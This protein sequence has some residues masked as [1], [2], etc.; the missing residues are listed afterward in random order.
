MPP[1]RLISI[2]VPVL[3]E[4]Q[5]V[6]P[7]YQTL[8]ALQL[9]L[10]DRYQWEMLFTDN[11][12]NDQTFAILSELAARDPRV[13]ALRF[14]RNFGYQASILTG[15]LNARGDAIIQLDCDMQDPPQMIPR[16]LQLWEEGN[17]VVYGVRQTRDEPAAMNLTRKLFYRLINL[18]SEHPLPLDAGDFRLLD[19]RIVTELAR[20]EDATPYLRG[21]IAMLGFRQVGVPYERRS[22]TAG[23][24]KFYFKDLVGLAIDGI[25]NHS[26]LPLRL[27]NYFCL[28]LFLLTL[29]LVFIYLSAWFFTDHQWPQGFA[30]LLLLILL[31]AC[32]NAMFFGILGEYIARIF[33]QV[34]RS[35][36][37][38]VEQELNPVATDQG[39]RPSRAA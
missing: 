21:T 15:Y 33:R 11:H 25:L 32:S 24:S 18:M 29:L 7:L 16:F 35:P 9:E 19:R 1:T 20:I 12:S 3:N 5:N 34:K 30:T 22:R 13:R 14:S 27:A 38:I 4:E 26:I 28:G 2:V 10:G 6:L 23:Q 39:A 37:T 31:S 36:L 17:L 8:C